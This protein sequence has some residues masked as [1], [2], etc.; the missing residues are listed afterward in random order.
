M[1]QLIDVAL[2]QNVGVADELLAVERS[3]HAMMQC[4]FVFG[5]LREHRTQLQMV[6]AKIAQ[7]KQ[8]A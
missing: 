1:L 7:L 2:A 3:Q 6:L 5:E 4:F 8:L